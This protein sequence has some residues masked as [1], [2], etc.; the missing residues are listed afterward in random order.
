MWEGAGVNSPCG[1]RAL[2]AQGRRSHWGLGARR[3]GLLACPQDTGP[4]LPK[5]RVLGVFS[6]M[7]APG[8]HLGQRAYPWMGGGGVEGVGKREGSGA[9]RQVTPG[10]LVQ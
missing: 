9:E 7:L 5:P 4:R 6:T 8:P 10:S 2:V 1:E 3:G